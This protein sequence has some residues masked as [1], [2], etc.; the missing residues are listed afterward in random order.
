MEC[1]S[2][3]D[4]HNLVL[5]VMNLI[6]TMKER[7]ATQ[8]IYSALFHIYEF[9][10]VKLIYGDISQNRDYRWGVG[11]LLEAARWNLPEY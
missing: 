5:S 10:K 11:Q 6:D 4:K 9:H 7:N 8:R 1:V 3:I 2:T